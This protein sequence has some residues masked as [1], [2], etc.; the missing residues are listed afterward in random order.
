[1]QGILGNLDLFTYNSV[2]SEGSYRQTQ[3]DC[4]DLDIEVMDIRNS[5]HCDWNGLSDKER[6]SCTEERERF[7]LKD[8]TLEFSGTQ[9]LIMNPDFSQ[10]IYYCSLFTLLRYSVFLQLQALLSPNSEILD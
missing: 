8:T 7:L 6:K 3:W 5:A 10:V 4:T 2:W 9:T 1:M